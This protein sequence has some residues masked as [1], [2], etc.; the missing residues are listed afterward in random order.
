[1]I[2][3]RVAFLWLHL[4]KRAFQTNEG[5][6]CNF[7]YLQFDIFLINGEGFFQAPEGCVKEIHDLLAYLF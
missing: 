6:G 1:M 5:V 2:M 7:V 4:K 3:F